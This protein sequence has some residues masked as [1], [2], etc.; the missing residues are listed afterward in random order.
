MT[1]LVDDQLLGG[2][3]R[4][5]R[6]PRRCQAVF[7]T[8]YWYVRLCQAVLSATDRPGVLSAPFEA[9][10][11]DRRAAVLETI[12]EL[13]DDIGLVSLR[14]LAPI[15]GNLR[16][17]HNLNILGMEALAAAVYLQADVYL[18]AHSPQLEGAL[19]REGAA[20]EVVR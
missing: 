1:Q 13:P 5:A 2:I 14:D 12:L 7:T 18:S 4:G 3:L 8:G 17:R 11:A 16:R 6:P 19:A 9:L 20:V 15:I 10:P